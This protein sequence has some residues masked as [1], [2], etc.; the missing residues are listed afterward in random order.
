MS[1]ILPFE[2]SYHRRAANKLPHRNNARHLEA[3]NFLYY[4]LEYSADCGACAT[5]GR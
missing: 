1:P 4:F 2:D 5:A 3:F